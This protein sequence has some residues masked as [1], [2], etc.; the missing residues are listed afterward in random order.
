LQIRNTLN[1]NSQK[2][3]KF[4]SQRGFHLYLDL[5]DSSVSG[6]I[7]LNDH[8][9]PHV[10][11]MLVEHTNW[12]ETFLDIGANIGWFSL[13]AGTEMRKFNSKGRVDAF[14]PNPNLA[15]VLSA[16]ILENC[17]MER[18]AVR[19]AAVS[20]ESGV[21]QLYCSDDHV[22]G[23][24]LLDESWQQFAGSE[25]EVEG[26]RWAPENHA[27]RHVPTHVV[28]T[29]KLDEIYKNYD[30]KI[31]SIK[32][33][34][35][36]HEPLA[37]LGAANIVKEHKPK[38]IME[39][40]PTAMELSSKYPVEKLVSLLDELGYGIRSGVDNDNFI[41]LSEISR[42]VEEKGYYDFLATSRF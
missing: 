37:L 42:L 4:Y 8:F 32:L 1:S 12:D 33:D 15:V 23:S 2:I 36:G 13:I 34:I 6:N 41:G 11:K 16:S 35:E 9:E 29:V 7:W 25:S 38:I 39:I 30:K 31:G 3:T 40:N 20:V 27:S 21:A 28:S 26:N 17:L 19:T 14:E 18:I 22:A 5:S 10:E 24:K